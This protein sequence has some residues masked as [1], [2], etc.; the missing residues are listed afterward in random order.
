LSIG[1]VFFRLFHGNIHMPR[2]S[3][4]ELSLTLLGRPKTD[5]KK[6]LGDRLVL[7]LLGV[8]VVVAAAA[9]ALR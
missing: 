1:I 6:S 2:Y 5:F 4:P 3:I 7:V 8:V 9:A